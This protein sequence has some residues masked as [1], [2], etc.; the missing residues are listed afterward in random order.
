MVINKVIKSF[1][2]TV[3]QLALFD[4]RSCTDFQKMFHLY[5]LILVNECKSQTAMYKNALNDCVA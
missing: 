1:N 5:F 2:H 3:R 4:E